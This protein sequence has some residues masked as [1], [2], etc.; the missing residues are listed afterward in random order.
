MAGSRAKPKSREYGQTDHVESMPRLFMSSIW[1][2]ISFI[3]AVYASFVLILY[4]SQSRLLYY[5]D[6]PS[7]ALAATP[8][9][10]GL[11]YRSLQIPTTDG[12]TLH[13]WFLP[14]TSPR[15]T[16]LFF[17]GNA[18]NISHRLESLQL[19]HELGLSVLIFDYRGF[20]QSGGSPSEPGSYQDAEAV[21][22]YLTE[23]IG[24]PPAEI[25]LFGRSLGAAV[26][27]YL[28][29]RH[30]PGG[31]ILESAFTSVP[32][33]A[34]ELY[35][36][37]PARWL[38]RFRYDSRAY[39]S[40]VTSP[41]LVIHSRD[42]EIIPYHHGQAL[43]AAANEPKQFV[44]IRGDHNGGFMISSARYRQGLNRF[45]ERYQATGQH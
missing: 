36:L 32:D 43:Y 39:L 44:E 40:S 18:G 42:D 37:L 23:Q 45:I 15:A 16:L 34:S 2:I 41:V 21:W 29:S 13:G 28:A 24:V 19:F 25:L 8:G 4:L 20:G 12:V 3:L 33:L 17:H 31:L 26:A 22:R 6:L 10:V 38:S 5:P 30:R 9:Q 35:P 27:A 7:R 14:V 1:S 11:D